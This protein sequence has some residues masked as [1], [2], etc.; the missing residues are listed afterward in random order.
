MDRRDERGGEEV[1]APTS[2]PKVCGCGRRH[3]AAGW[4]GLVR[5]GEHENVDGDLLE[6]RNCPCG[7]T[8]SI[9]QAPAARDEANDRRRT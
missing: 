2:W 5:V 9:M 1:P 8:L 3:S 6:L 7:S 4:A